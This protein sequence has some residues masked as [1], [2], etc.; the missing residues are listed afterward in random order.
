MRLPWGDP[1]LKASCNPLGE[2]RLEAISVSAFQGVDLPR[3]WND[4]DR[5]PDDDPYDQLE[6]VFQRVR[7]ALYAWG[8]GRAISRATSSGDRAPWCS[9]CPSR[10]CG[11]S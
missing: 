2:L 11:P 9:T 4:T 10:G 1:E 7:A 3:V 8:A 5:E 6:A